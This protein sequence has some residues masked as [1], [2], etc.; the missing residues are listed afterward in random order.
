[1][2]TIGKKLSLG[3]GIIFLF[4]LLIGG[5]A[6]FSLITIKD[7]TDA[8]GLFSLQAE[9][10]SKMRE[11]LFKVLKINSFYV[12]GNL[13]SRFEYET[14]IFE[15]DHIFSDLEEV[16]LDGKEQTLLSRIEKDYELLKNKTSEIIQNFDGAGDPGARASRIILLDEVDD[17]RIDIVNSSENL[18]YSIQGKLEEEKL[19]ARRVRDWGIYITIFISLFSF[20][21][22][23][24]GSFFFT[25][26]FLT[27]P[28]NKL[29]KAAITLGEGGYETKIDITST[30]E[31][32]IL[33]RTFEAM[34]KDIENYTNNLEGLVEERTEELNKAFIEIKRHEEILMINQEKLETAKEQAEAANRAKSEFLA[35][36]SHE[37]RTPM[38]AVIGMSHL[39]LQK[40][41]DPKQRDYLTKI[42]FS[43]KHLLQIINEILD[44]SKIEAGKFDL[45]SVKF[46][47]EEVLHKTVIMEANK[48]HKKGLE[49]FF[50]LNPDVPNLLVGDPVRLGQI[51]INL[52]SNA[53]KFTEAGEIVLQAEPREET[54]EHVT[55]QFSV[56]DTGIGLTEDQISRLFQSFA[57]ADTSTTRK[58]GGT[59]LGLVICK[60]LVEMM[61]GE[62]WVESE[63]G[64]GSVFNLTAKFR[65]FHTRRQTERVAPRELQGMSILVVDDNRPTCKMLQGNLESLNFHAEIVESGREAIARLENAEKQNTP[66]KLVLID[67]IMPDM[68]G[69]ET[70]QLIRRNKKLSKQPKIIAMTASDNEKMSNQAK[71]VGAEAVLPKPVSRSLIFDTI[72]KVFVAVMKEAPYF[73]R[74]LSN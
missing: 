17:S 63:F 69:T 39:A 53:I 31:M 44:F 46:D 70:I 61:D 66:F 72:L 27:N 55:I 38:N 4:M 50:E 28:L 58:F 41:P 59:G 54:P 49:I 42:D 40:C 51:L 15:L 7:H 65:K 30:D 25:R 56:S 13:E 57:Q 20:I 5:V 16:E 11:V 32:G 12:E 29:K 45:E 71:K 34:A 33:A 2:N 48:A 60:N 19:S 18:Y 68:D 47:I 43:A 1:M 26:R 35:N 10:I 62:I 21:F 36:M 23:I 67:L 22:G 9:K 52:V 24:G 37:I 74:S 14:L 73:S 8:V 64:K 3:F 6:S